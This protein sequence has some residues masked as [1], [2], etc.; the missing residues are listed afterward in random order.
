MKPVRVPDLRAM[1]DRGEK[2]AVLTAYDYTMGRLLDRAGIDVILVG[3]S[4]G[5]VILGFDNTLPVTLDMVEQIQ[6][7]G[8]IGADRQLPGGF[9][10][11]LSQGVFKAALE[12]L[13]VP[14]V[15]EH[16]FA[17][18]GQQQILGGTVDEPL[19]QLGFKPLNRQGNRRLSA[20]QFLGGPRKTLLC[21][22]CEKDTQRMHL[23]KCPL[24][25]HRTL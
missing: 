13:E 7:A 25:L 21:G 23:H 6:R 1:K 15:L 8:F 16:D 10:A 22:H 12:V 19:P 24:Y 20:E 17:R 9:V 18:I 2:I 5:M 14:G 3:D 4:A 11:Q